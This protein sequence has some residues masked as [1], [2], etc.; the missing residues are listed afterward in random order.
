M[1][2]KRNATWAQRIDGVFLLG[3]YATPVLILAGWLLALVSF[4]IDGDSLRGV[5]SMLGV[6]AY[7][8]VGNFAP[9]FEIGAAVRLDRTPRK[10]LL[11]PL[12]I[13]GFLV[14][15]ISVTQ[16]T[17]SQIPVPYFRRAFVWHKTE[18]TADRAQ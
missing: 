8:S 5:I 6:S 18:R 13:F 10:I 15:L 2:K 16:A 17:V 1:L 9:F 11:M 3:V 14:S 4:Y 12:N 7:T